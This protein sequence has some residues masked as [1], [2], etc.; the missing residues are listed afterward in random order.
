MNIHRTLFSLATVAMTATAAGAQQPAQQTGPLPINQDARQVAQ[1][2]DEHMKRLVPFGYS[3]SLLVGKDGQVVLA[4]GYGLAD[5]ENNVA[6]TPETVFDIGSITKQFTAAAILKLEMEGKVSVNDP[7]SRWFPDVPA[8]K[9]GMT[10]HHLLTHS[11]GL[12]DVFGGDYQ[13]AERD[14]LAGV[15]LASRLQ[16]APGTR[17]DYSNAGYSLLAMVVEKA[18]GMPYEDYAR[19]KL[20]APAGMTR[21]G[22]RGVQWR[23]GELAVGYRGGQRWG[24]PTDHLWAADGPYWNLRG[25]GGVLSSVA[26]LFRWHQA[27]EGDAILSAEAKRKMWMPHVPEDPEGRSHYGYGWAIGPTA[28]GTKLIAHNGGNGI[29]FADFRR[30][31]DEGVVVLVMSNTTEAPAE[32]TLTAVARTIFGGGEVVAPPAAAGGDPARA[33]AAAGTYRLSGDATMAVA[34]DGERLVLRPQ[35]QEA[36]ALLN[37]GVGDARMDSLGARAVAMLRAAADGDYALLLRAFGPEVPEGEIRAEHEEYMTD[38]RARLGALQGVE[39]VGT[40]PRGGRAFTTVRLRFERGT[41]LLR[42]TWAG[43]RVSGVTPMREPPAAV[44]VPVAPDA[45]ASYDIGTGAISRV[46]LEA[47][48]LVVDTPAG[49]VRASR[50]E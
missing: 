10:L 11:S 22:Y 9:Q 7:V 50:S 48:A 29:F 26:D 27:L 24:T 1:R 18:S 40:S 46:R 21:T 5:R 31:V 37:G 17:Y 30:Y 28:R 20:W 36:Y 25:N 12:Q 6:V 33:A 15:I 42:V 8:D 32:R 34:A 3:G 47:G 23:P 35:G 39:H 16:W 44:F 14:S 19:Q 4:H 43:D 38:A 49:P 13:V 45:W 2:L 41:P